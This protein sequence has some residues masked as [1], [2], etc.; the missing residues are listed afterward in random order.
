M[1]TNITSGIKEALGSTIGRGCIGTIHIYHSATTMRVSLVLALFLAILLLPLGVQAANHYVRQG[2]TGS[3]NGADWANAWTDLPTTFTRGDT[4]YIASGNYGTHTF[5]SLSGTSYVYVKKATVAAHGTDTGW[6]DSYAS[7]QAVFSGA[8]VWSINMSYLDVDG[9]TGS[10][11]SGHG[12]VL[13]STSTSEGSGPIT[14]AY[15]STASHLWFRHVAF[16]SPVNGTSTVRDIYNDSSTTTDWNFQY[17]YITGG[18]VAIGFVAGGSSGLLL[19]YSYIKNIG[20]NVSTNHSAAITLADFTNAT[21]RYNVF[22]TMPYTYNTT[23]IEPQFSS[24]NIYV[25]GNTFKFTSTGNVGQGI[26]AITSSDTCTNCLIYSN[27]MYNL[28]SGTNTGVWCGNYGGSSCVVRNNVWKSCQNASIYDP[29]GNVTQ[30]NNSLNGSGI[31]FVNASGG[32]FHLTGPTPA[33]YPLA[34]PYNADPDGNVRSQWSVGAFEFAPGGNVSPPL[35]L[36]IV[37]Q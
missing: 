21:I 27:T 30:S 4:Y 19:E 6:N 23:F 7:G 34:A 10:G 15:G 26:F 11:E 17:C 28:T 24:S 25:Y 20:S 36:R 9:V 31:N 2:A 35:N 12:I 33:G 14:C 18:Y 3:A 16:T 37:S 1:R 29:G 13:S 5:P 22:D 8:T 32:D